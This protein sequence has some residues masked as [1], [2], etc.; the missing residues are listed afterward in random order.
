LR[1]FARRTLVCAALTFAAATHAAA[2]TEPRSVSALSADIDALD[3]RITRLED[4]A[5]IERL[6]R[7]YGYYVDVSQFYDVTDLFAADSRLEIGGRGVF[8]GKARVFQYMRELGPTMAPAHDVMYTHQQLQPLV[9]LAPD[10]ET[11]AARWAPFVMAGAVWGDVT[12]ENRYVKEDGVWKIQSLRAPFN[13]YTEYTAGWAVRTEPNTRP[14]SWAPPPD[15]PPSVVT[16]T[17]PNYHVE[18]FHFANPVTGRTAPPPHPAAGG[19]ALAR[20]APGGER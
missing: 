19:T 12:Y 17:F 5:A 20:A 11:A 15:L 13:M 7:A 4:T 8:L 9:T 18:P 3:A 6:Q 10:G 1:L 16:L 14:E 2:Q